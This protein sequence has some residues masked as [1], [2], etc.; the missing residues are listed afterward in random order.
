MV[1]F[2]RP[3]QFQVVL[4]NFSPPDPGGLFGYSRGGGI[5]Q[6][7][8]LDHTFLPCI[9]PPQFILIHCFLDWLILKSIE[10]RLSRIPWDDASS[11][12]NRRHTDPCPR[13]GPTGAPAAAP[14]R[15][16]PW[17]GPLAPPSTAVLSPSEWAEGVGTLRPRPIT[18]STFSY[19]IHQSPLV[20]IFTEEEKIFR[21]KIYVSIAMK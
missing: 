19:L 20:R 21:T 2:G 18:C 13:P 17:A 8:A 3:F 12:L 15:Q 5:S 4:D 1:A 7:S 14:P 16:A 6:A 10:S 11:G 9:F